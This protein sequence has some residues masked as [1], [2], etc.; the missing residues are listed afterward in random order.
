MLGI[1]TP[2]LPILSAACGNSHPA[3]G[4]GKGTGMGSGEQ[5]VGIST[6]R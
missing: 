3:G 6:L 4:G 5:G 2:S 1:F